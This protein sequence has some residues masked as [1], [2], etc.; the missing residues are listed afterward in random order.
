[1]KTKVLFALLLGALLSTGGRLFAQV[2]P[3]IRTG[4]AASTF[5][6]PGNLADNNEVTLANTTGIFVTLPVN[7]SL[8][9]QPEVNYIRKGRSNE[10]SLLKNSIP[11][12]YTVNYLQ[13]PLQ[14]QFRNEEMFKSS[15]SVF[16]LNAG[17]YT[18]FALNSREHYQ[19]DDGARSAALNHNL[20]N[21]W[22]ITV[23]IGFQTPALKQNLRMD[24]KYDMGL[25]KIAYQ[26]EDYRTK[27]LSLTLGIVL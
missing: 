19:G 20:K 10:P 3:G 1:M 4:L 18:A 2:Q 15:K 13:V 11:A 26:D 27:C 7:R 14:V 8:A 17:P 9:F 6:S 5:A 24:L 25:S 12:D 23:G 16:F 21:D 22:G